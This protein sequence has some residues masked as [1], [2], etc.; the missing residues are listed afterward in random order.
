MEQKKLKCIVKRLLPYTCPSCGTNRI[1]IFD[2]FD[3]R[4]NY[5]LLCKY[6]NED[7]IK[8]KLENTD[9]KYMKCDICKSIFVLDWTRDEIP[10]PLYKN[11]YNDFERR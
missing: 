8:K 2:K 5:S 4:I 10:Y 3:R 1:S 11:I 9:L 7:Q 6:N